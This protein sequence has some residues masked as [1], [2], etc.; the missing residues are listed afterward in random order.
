MVTEVLKKGPRELPMLLSQPEKVPK[1]VTD[2]IAKC[3]HVNKEERFQEA[4]DLFNRLTGV[5][6]E[7]EEER[8]KQKS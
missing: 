6:K 1:A 5:F 8:E 3:L 4:Q 7:L 2:T